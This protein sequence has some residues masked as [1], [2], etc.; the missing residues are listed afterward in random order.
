VKSNTDVKMRATLVRVAR[1]HFLFVLLISSQI[2]IYDAWGL[3]DPHS[4]RLRW[5]FA[6]SLL[7]VTTI[8]W[9]IARGPILKRNIYN[10]LIYLLI[11]VDII[12]VSANV[13]M[14]RG[15]ASRSVLLYAIP[16]IISA[17]L[18][19]RRAIFATALLTIATYISTT[20]S[21]F[22][23]NF[24]EGYKVELYGEVGFYS[25]TMLI[26]AEFLWTIVKQKHNA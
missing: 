21:Y 18:G 1:T 25:L 9:Y 20:T 22:A 6:M 23:L 10:S 24:N 14:Q 15:M 5:I 8:V 4:V 16:I 17:T 7:A 26:L 19:S 11:L 13:Y 2:I 12:A 3:I